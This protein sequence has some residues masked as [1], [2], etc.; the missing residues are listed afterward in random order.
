M[1]NIHRIQ[2][3]MGNCYLI[4]NGA[5]AVLVDTCRKAYRNKI[6]KEC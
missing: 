5:G 4:T 3:G 6:L 2:C 1:S